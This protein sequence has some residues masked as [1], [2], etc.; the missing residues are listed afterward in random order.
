MT[1]LWYFATLIYAGA[2]FGPFASAEQCLAMRAQVKAPWR[3]TIQLVTSCWATDGQVKHGEF[4]PPPPGTIP[5]P[6]APDLPPVP[7]LAFLGTSADKVGQGSIAFAPDGL[8][9]GVFRLTFGD[10]GKTLTALKLETPSGTWDTDGATPFWALGVSALESSDLL[11]ELGFTPQAGGVLYLYAADIAGTNYFA[12]GKTL[13][14]TIT[15]ADGT[16]ETAAV[17]I[18]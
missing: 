10:G 3:D 15:W 5:P 18:P 12:S 9:D 6:P 11:P 14:L 4:L 7:T 8:P 16:T 13:T 1:T 17:T 2:I